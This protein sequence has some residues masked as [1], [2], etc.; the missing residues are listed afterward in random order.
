MHIIIYYLHIII[1]F[2]LWLRVQMHIISN[3]LN[4][5]IMYT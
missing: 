3:Y 4:I 5:V 2:D 1:S